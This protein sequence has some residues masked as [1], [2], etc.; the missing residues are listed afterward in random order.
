[1]LCLWKR[2]DYKRKE[3]ASC[4]EPGFSQGNWYVS[5]QTGSHKSYLPCEMAENPP[6]ASSPLKDYELYLQRIVL[7]ISVIFVI[8]KNMIKIILSQICLVPED[9]S[10]NFIVLRFSLEYDIN[11]C[12]MKKKKKKKKKNL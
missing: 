4:G 9:N 1:M 2:V 10:V 3:F 6:S 8:I 12:K 5:K 7:T 11:L